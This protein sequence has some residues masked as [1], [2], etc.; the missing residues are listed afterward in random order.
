MGLNRWVY[1]V[2]AYVLLLRDEYPPFRLDQGPVDPPA[3]APGPAR[4]PGP[5]PV[6]QA[7]APAPGSRPPWSS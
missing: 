2:G 5:E 4:E 7:G 3:Q 6:P 1:R